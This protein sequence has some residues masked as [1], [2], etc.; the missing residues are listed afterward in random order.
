M[1]KRILSLA[2]DSFA[3]SAG[4]P[5]CH[6]VRSF[7]SY[8]RSFAIA[9]A[10][11]FSVSFCEF[12]CHSISRLYRQTRQLKILR[13]V[14]EDQESSDTLTSTASLGAAH[15]RSFLLLCLNSRLFTVLVRDWSRS[16]HS[17]CGGTLLIPEHVRQKPTP[18]YEALLRSERSACRGCLN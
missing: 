12:E 1:G 4:V 3:Q 2:S 5:A 13:S 6:A 8:S 9:R 7:G 16:S 15:L 14:S 18:R 11:P 10:V 17:S